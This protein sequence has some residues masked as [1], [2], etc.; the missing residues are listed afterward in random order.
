MRRGRKRAKGYP[1]SKA[2]QVVGGAAMGAGSGGEGGGESNGSKGVPKEERAG[3]HRRMQSRWLEVRPCMQVAVGRVGVRVMSGDPPSYAEQV[4]GGAAMRAGSGGEGGG[5]SN[6]SKGVPKDERAGT[7]RRMQSRWL[8]VRPCVQVAVGRVGVRVMS[9]DPPSYAEQVVGG[10]AMRAGSGGEGG[11]ESNG[12]KGVPKDER[13]GTHRRMQSR[14]LEV[15]PCVQVAV[16]R[17]GV[18][19]M[20]GDP[21]S[22]AEQ[23]VGGAAMR[24]G[25]GGEGGG[26]SNG[27]KGVPKEERA[28][29]HRRMQ[30]RWLEVRPCM[31]VAVGRV[32]VRVMSGDPPSY[33]EQVVGGAAM[34]AGSGGE[35]GGESNGSKGVPK[36]ER[37]GTHRRMQ[38]R[39][40]E[41]RPCVQVA[42]GRVGVR[43]MV[44]KGFQK[45]RERGPTVVCRAGGWRRES[46]DPPS[47]AEQVVGGAAMRAGSGGEGGGESNGS[48][49]VPKEERA[50]T[51]RRMQ[52]RWLEVR[53]CVQ[54]AVGRVG[55]RVMSGDPPSYA[56]QMVG[57]AAMRAGSGGEGGGESNGSKGVPKEERAGTHRR[58]QSRWLE[59]R[60]C[61]Q[62]A[63]GRVGVRVMSGDPPSYAEQV[64]GGAAMR[65]GSGGEGGGESNGSKGVPKEER[66]GTHR[67]MQS[68]WL[69]VRPCVQVAVGRVGVRVMSGDPPSYA[70]Q[71][72]GGA[73]M[74]AGSGGEGGGESN[75]SKG[76]P[77]EERAG[78]HRRMQSRWLEVRPCVQVAVGRVGVRVMSGD[79]PSYAEQVVGGAAM[80]AGSGGE[81]GGESNGSKGVPKEERAGTHRRMQSR[82]LEVRPCVQVAVGRVGVRVMSGD[83][84]SYAEQVVGG[85]AMRAGS[86]GEGGGESNGSKG[87]P[88]DERA[89]THR[90]MQSRWLE[91]RPCVQ[92]AVGKVGVRV[93]SGDPP[94]YAEQVV[95]GAAMHAGS[96]GE[97]GGESNGSKGVPKE[98]RAGT[99]R[100]MQS[101]WLEV[102]P[103][104]QVA[105]GRVG[106]R[107]MS[108]DPPSYAEQV[109]GGAAMRAGSGGEGGGESNG[110]KGVPK[111]ERAGTHRRMQSRWLEV[112]PCVQVAVGRVGVRVM[113]GDPPSYAEQVVGGAAMRAGSGG[114]GGG[115]SNGSKGVPKDE[116]AGTHRRMQSRWLEVRPCVQ[117]AVGRV[118]VRV[119]S[120]DPPSYAE[121][122]VGGAAMRAGSGGEGGGESNG[123]KGVPKEERAGTHRRMQS[124]WLEVRPCVQVA[125][126]R[127]GVRVMSGDPPSYAEQ[128]VGGAAMRAGSGGEGG[129]E[130]NGSKGVPKEER[131]GT[132]RRMQSRW[133]EVRPCVQVAVGRVG[134]RVM[135]GDPPSYAEQVVGGAAM[136]AG[137]GG[138]GGGESNGSKGVPKEERAGTHRR[139][140]SRWLEV[141]PCVQV[142]VG[143]VGVRVMSGDPPSYA[144]QVVG[145]AAMRAGSG[146]E[147]GGESNGSKGVPKEERAGTH[148]RMQSRW[149]E[150]R[151]CVQVAVGRV[152]VRVMVLK[153]FQK[154]RERGPTVVCRAGGWRCGHACR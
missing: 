123:S 17:V 46:G 21:P 111:E 12:S 130:S 109:V 13:A 128:V 118:G 52:S 77:K 93:M 71:V 65:A 79:P 16:G 60:P 68:R 74:R 110:S 126:G 117:V 143:R 14:W 5:E 34:R 149:L 124:R 32:G 58:M 104:V 100:R 98:E 53:P 81:G 40:L 86:G 29:T 87:V 45:T 142:A 95:G 47:Y 84:P 25:S 7:H 56:E 103:C 72:V 73:A 3:T 135:S 61:V 38:S 115:E 10:A 122:V 59:V 62:V 102:R 127:V 107:V 129:G 144:E 42:V 138:E 140:Q 70:E 64:V 26:E 91:V 146:G 48:K 83:P 50:G 49:G 33:A 28:G 1:P 125:V 6:G 37:A 8:E 82:W 31:Q 30:S 4:V 88:K 94:S 54:V 80:R 106:V 19:V 152:G 154:T 137:S 67:P 41:V 99:H 132:H 101:R 78:T 136:R 75:G 22:Y 2:E 116:R 131:A 39:W 24:A 20:S 66:A 145:G 85:A 96:G 134:V 23:V 133:L 148:R 89:G 150:V 119:M 97:G 121:Q 44:L 27:S 153:G 147:G 35:G 92:V 120:G 55:V 105:V 113:S 139:M 15:R 90:R 57:G 51:H 9:G 69:E 76:V 151:P 108:G 141:R 112:R 63:V 43:V 18:R 36:E 11:G 114:E